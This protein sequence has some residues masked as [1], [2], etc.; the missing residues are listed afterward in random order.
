MLSRG[1]KWE[2]FSLLTSVAG[3]GGN[4]KHV[5]NIKAQNRGNPPDLA[6]NLSKSQAKGWRES[7]Y[8]M[9]GKRESRILKN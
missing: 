7:H 3:E 4:K 1:F 2:W 9:E 8:T 5:E 6:N